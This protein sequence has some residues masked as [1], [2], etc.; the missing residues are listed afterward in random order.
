MPFDGV[1]VRAITL[2]L[3]NIIVESRIDKIHMPEKDEVIMIM[4]NFRG[5]HR[6]KIS[7][8]SAYPGI[9]LTQSPQKNPPSPPNFCMF[10]RK[11][12]AGGIIKDVISYGYERYLGILIESRNEL[13][14]MQN[15]TLMIELTGRNCNLVLLNASGKILDSLKHIDSDMS[16]VREIMPAR[17]YVFIPS[18]DKI[19]PETATP[20]DVLA[21]EDT[22]IEKAILQNIQ[23][24]SPVSDSDFADIRKLY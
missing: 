8:N 23:G 4:R 1:T 13:G 7:L 2:E 12:I 15:K 9:Y 19:S 5:N 6:L 11:H 22:P 14:D 18:Q 20:H 21:V 17:N 3:K 16:S 10:L 24:F